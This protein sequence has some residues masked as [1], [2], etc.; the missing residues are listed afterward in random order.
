[1]AP[2]VAS[3]IPNGALYIWTKTWMMN[4]SISLDKTFSSNNIVTFGELEYNLAMRSTTIQFKV[5]ILN[6][7]SQ[8]VYQIKL[9]KKTNNAF[10]KYYTNC[11]RKIQQIIP[12]VTITNI[13]LGIRHFQTNVLFLIQS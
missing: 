1:M 8:I 13:A 5:K 4:L 3:V 7:F 10:I 6:I 2:N 12:F 9:Y 11:G